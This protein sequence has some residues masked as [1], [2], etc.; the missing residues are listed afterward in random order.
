ML[1]P[2]V[3]FAEQHLAEGGGVMIHCPLV[4]A[5]SNFGFRLPVQDSFWVLQ[6]SGAEAKLGFSAFLSTWGSSGF[7]CSI[8]VGFGKVLVQ[9]LGR[10][11][12]GSKEG[13][14]YSIYASQVQAEARSG[15]GA[16]SMF[17]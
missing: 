6:G 3:G 15:S 7:W 14:G 1:A 11:L 12:E 16:A 13:S 5:L 9:K 8:Q 17:V 4:T 2:L 10:V